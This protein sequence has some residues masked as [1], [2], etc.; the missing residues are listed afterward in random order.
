ML[1]VYMWDEKFT[2]DMSRTYIYIYINIYIYIYIHI[3]VYMYIYQVYVHVCVFHKFYY[4]SAIRGQQECD[5][6]LI[7]GWIRMYDHMYT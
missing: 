5:F 1:Q 7:L 2:E 6:A 3:Y 4:L